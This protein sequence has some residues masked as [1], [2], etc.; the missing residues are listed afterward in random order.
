[1]NTPTVQGTVQ[2]MPTPDNPNGC[3]LNCDAGQPTQSPPTG[4]QN[5]ATTAAPTVTGTPTPSATPTSSEETARLVNKDETVTVTVTETQ[6]PKPDEKTDE[7]KC[8]TGDKLVNMG[9]IIVGGI[10]T[11][12]GGAMIP[13][14][15]GGG[16]ALAGPSAIMLGSGV[17]EMSKC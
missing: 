4:N 16:L 6:K 13:F 9:S 17:N 8:T 14:T 12:V 7:P 3:I 11:T 1:M 2:A 10:G 5:P 15:F